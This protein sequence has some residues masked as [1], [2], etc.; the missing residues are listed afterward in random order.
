MIIIMNHSNKIKGL[1]KLIKTFKFTRILNLKKLWK[2][3]KI[4]I[5]K[6]LLWNIS[7]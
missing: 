2:N 5:N 7:L 3:K 1:W 4:N 6:F